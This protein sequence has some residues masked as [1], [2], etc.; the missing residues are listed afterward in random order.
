[1]LVLS[2]K[3]NESVIIPMDDGNQI[4]VLVVEI[5]GDK[6]RL[7]FSAPK[8]VP[9]HREEVWIAIQQAS[10]DKAAAI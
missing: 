1:M 4:E 5:R 8:D 6:I 3:E 7:G 9:I 10:I 2:R